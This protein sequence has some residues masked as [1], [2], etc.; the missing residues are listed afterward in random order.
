[1]AQNVISAVSPL[2]HLQ[3]SSRQRELIA[4]ARRLARERFAARADLGGTST[5]YWLPAEKSMVN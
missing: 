2:M 5:R 4:V 1:L 3:P